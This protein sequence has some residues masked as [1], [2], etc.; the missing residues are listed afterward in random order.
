MSVNSSTCS[1]TGTP[2]E[3]GIFTP[4]IQLTVPGYSGQITQ[5]AAI[6]IY[7]PPV[8][9]PD[10]SD[11][12]TFRFTDAYSLPANN[13]NVGIN[14]N[15]T[16]IAGE[17]V[18]YSIASGNLPP[19]MSIDPS[20]GLISGAIS[21]TGLSTFTVQAL[22]TKP[23][24]TATAT[25]QPISINVTDTFMISYG[26]RYGTVGVALTPDTPGIL[27]Y[28]QPWTS[29][30]YA[31]SLSNANGM[32]GILPTGLSLDPTTGTISGTPTVSNWGSNDIYYG[33]RVDVTHNG[34]SF[35]KYT[36]A[37][38]AIQ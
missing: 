27:T 15:W 9:Y 34:V 6:T 13:I 28:E 35:T 11:A 16:P 23:G 4:T 36:S 21:S 20:T 10:I 22:V 24:A 37:R 32:N 26:D 25:S 5:Q 30:T 18:T 7:G 17:T 3:A 1:I 19:G 2:T 38:I 12:S 8:T 31:Y 29:V 14:P 33:V